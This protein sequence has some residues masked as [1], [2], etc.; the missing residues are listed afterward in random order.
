MAPP[1]RVAPVR[2]YRSR[3]L[4]PAS[5]LDLRP[6]SPVGPEM[7][8]SVTRAEVSPSVRVPP[9][10]MVLGGVASVQF[11]SAFA[12]ELFGR[13]GPAGV[14]L[15]R[16]A[17]G[18][19]LLTAAVRPRLRGRSR[20]D[21]FAAAGFGVMLA[22]MNWSFYEALARLPL[23]PAVTV[24]FL[25]PL[26]VAVVG[27][28]R[29]LDVLWVVLAGGG[30]AILGFGGSHA[31]RST[32]AAGAHTA[33]HAASHAASLGH[34]SLSP[35]GIAFALVAG[36][37]W[38]GYIVM[39]KRVGTAFSGLDGLAVALVVG[40]VLLLPAGLISGGHAF[41]EPAVLGGGLAVAMLSSVIPYSLELTAL[42][43]LSTAAFGL[44]MSLEPAVAALAGVI[45][46]GQPLNLRTAIAIGMVVIASAGSTLSARGAT[47]PPRDA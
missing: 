44:L 34:G 31:D 21:W 23:G 37:F 28:R 30:V 42:R 33:T 1:Q 3:E 26:A 43:R 9:Q 40:A 25:G 16:L 2:T 14:V 35:T 6:S 4:C 19:V 5:P 36:T 46:L 20:A 29:L 24:E 12:S 27:S 22:G 7:M 32:G 11:G 45:V 18:A 13:A 38:A 41:T 8:P 17:F 15:M 47:P 10:L 39:S